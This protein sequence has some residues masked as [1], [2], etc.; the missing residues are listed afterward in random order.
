MA[1][2]IT[3]K[4]V[5]GERTAVSYRLISIGVL[6]PSLSFAFFS[7]FLQ[8]YGDE[9]NKSCL[10]TAMAPILTCGRGNIRTAMPLCVYCSWPVPGPRRERGTKKGTASW[11]VGWHSGNLFGEMSIVKLWVSSCRMPSSGALM[12]KGWGGRVRKTKKFI[13]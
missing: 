6:F 7:F 5:C 13:L 11:P 4:Y 9:S 1:V 12:G 8:F 2:Q 10:G 3:G